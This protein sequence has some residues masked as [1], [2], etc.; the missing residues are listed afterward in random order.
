MRAIEQ[1]GY[2]DPR[3]VLHLAEREVP[4]FEAGQVLV[5][6]HA[7]S[8]NPYDWHLICGEPTLMRP[9]L[10]GIRAP[11][12]VVGADFAGVVEALGRDV[13]GVTVGDEVYGFADGAFAEYVAAPAG[14]V[15]R[16]PAT[17]TFAEAAAV[18]LAAITALQ[19]LRH[20]ELAEGQRVLIMGASGGVGTFAVQ[21]ATHMGAQATGVCSTSR[22]D[23][24]RS[25]GADHV[26]DYTTQ[27]PTS[28]P[29]RYDL[30]LQLGGTY[31]PR[32]LRRVLTPRG[33]LVQSHGDGSRLLGPLRSMASGAL[34]N[35]V[36][37]QRITLFVADEDTASLDELR[38][39][40]EAGHLRPVIDSEYPLERAGEAV[41]LVKDGRPAGKVVVTIAP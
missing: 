32:A 1:R 14:R 35:L 31:S 27:D 38:D 40:I 21:L 22:L 5:R 39:L 12:R 29:A 15:A 30:I 19:G 2:G 25:L 4:T 17:L 10:G 6:V 36:S 33:T 20:G 7:S 37:K 9:Q 13:Q 24:V 18:P 3:E 34:L 11:R 28:G 16:K 26:I 41:A 23:L 8:A